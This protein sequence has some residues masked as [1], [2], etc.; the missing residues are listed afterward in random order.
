MTL[1]GSAFLALWN[2]VDPA[3]AE[4]YD[5][6]HTFEHVPERVGV[7]GIRAARRYVGP[8]RGSDRYFT[9]YELDSLAVLASPGYQELIAQPTS[10]T[11]AM[12]TSFRN[13][14]RHACRRL[15]ST[16]IGIAGALATLRIGRTDAAVE[17]DAERMEAALASLVGTNGI[18]SVHLGAA[19]AD[20]DFAIASIAPA[21]D[22]HTGFVALIESHQPE[23]LAACEREVTR[24]LE[25][26]VGARATSAW[27]VF[28]LAFV[29]DKAMLAVPDA[30][31][32]PPRE[33][34]HVKFA[35]GPSAR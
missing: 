17:A 27:L 4:E 11:R 7:A 22:D 21:R 32:Q 26:A 15:C 20:P 3:R 33:D 6:W 23:S 5:C 9:L 16:G 35:H 1:H 25:A 30:R 31:R 29:I 2:D 28:E 24:A 13:F 14:R 12:R 18:V 8:G 34:L 10:W 19:V